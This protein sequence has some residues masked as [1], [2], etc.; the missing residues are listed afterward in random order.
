MRVLFAVILIAGIGLA[1]F[2]VYLA[3][4][5]INQY[6]TALEQQRAQLA[7][8]VPTTTVIVAAKPL[9]YGQR[10]AQG[11][12][13]RVAWPANAVPEGTFRT[14]E[15]VLPV[16]GKGPRTVL[17]AM[18]KDEPVM[19]VK[20]TDHGEDAGVSS[21]LRPGM[22]AFAISV[23]VAT[24]VSGFLKPGD[25]VD[26]YWTG[27]SRGQGMTRLILDGVRLIAIDQT[28]DADRTS[29][30]VARTVTVEAN[31]E[32]VARLAQAQAT[33]RLSLS[34]RGVEDETEVGRV[35]IDQRLFLGIE[36]E[37]EAEPV[38]RA[39]TIRTRRG[40]EVVEIEI[41]CPP[42]SGG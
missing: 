19:A 22:R 30:V 36:A 11:D 4:D 1:G 16:D 31:P 29:P 14:L 9:R 27:T 15:E 39:C 7:R 5:R 37:A 24:G 21:R 6:Q 23:D 42:G 40:G 26:V 17:R 33:G 32:Q 35:E 38:A 41:P 34:L 13:R 18:E 10:L 12:V 25:R 8:N 3:Q 28:A 20:V 2:A